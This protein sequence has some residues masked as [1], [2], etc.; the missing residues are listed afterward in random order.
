M[1]EFIINFDLKY[2]SD[3]EE[4]EERVNME[5]TQNISRAIKLTPQE[6]D[7]IEKSRHEENT[8]KQ[9]S[10]AVK[11]LQSWLQERKYEKELIWRPGRRCAT[12][13]TV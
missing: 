6:L 7:S 10:W 13:T 3:E 2:E 9:T 4:R 8:V 5:P 1:D 12:P 11:C